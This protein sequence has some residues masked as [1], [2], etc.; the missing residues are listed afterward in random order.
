ML[1]PYTKHMAQALGYTEATIQA[2]G[3]RMA[4]HTMSHPL[5]LAHPCIPV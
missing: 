2:L 3:T 4:L 1:H 5:T